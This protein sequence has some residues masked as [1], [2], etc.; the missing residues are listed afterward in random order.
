MPPAEVSTKE[1][2]NNPYGVSATEE[3]NLWNTEI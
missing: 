3:G 2:M 1:Y